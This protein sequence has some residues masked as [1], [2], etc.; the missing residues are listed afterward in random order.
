MPLVDPAAW[1]VQAALLVA[2]VA[3]AGA[4][5]RRLPWPRPLVIVV[6]AM[7]ALL[8]L[9]ALYAGGQALLGVLPGP[10]AVAE[11]VRL[12]QSGVADVSRYASPAPLTP[13]IRLLLVGGV[14]LVGLVVDALAVTYR[15]VAPAGLPLLALYSVAAGLAPGGTGWL[16][17]LIAA[18]GYLLLLLAEGRDRLSRW[19]RVFGG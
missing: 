14:T 17:F 6:Q 2:L 13:G 5:A 15:S 19:G 4:G 11:L 1:M 3:A 10:D 12:G 8:T 9:T 18:A 7:V 16:W